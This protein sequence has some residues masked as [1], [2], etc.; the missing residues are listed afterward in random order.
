M[1]SLESSQKGTLKS[2]PWLAET[3]EGGLE[4]LN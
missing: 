2:C 1:V 3:R 4:E